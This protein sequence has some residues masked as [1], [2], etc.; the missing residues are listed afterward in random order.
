M[1]PFAIEDHRLLFVLLSGDWLEE[2]TLRLRT[3][4][5]MMSKSD[6]MLEC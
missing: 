6:V 4:S 2:A 1:L 5:I 3:L